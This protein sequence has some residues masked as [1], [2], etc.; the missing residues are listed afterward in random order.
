MLIGCCVTTAG[1]KDPNLATLVVEQFNC[2]TP[3]YELM[4][5]FMVDEGW[6]FTFERGDKV[7]AFAE[8]NHLPVFGHMLVWQFVTRKWLFEDQAGKPLAREKAL[9]NLKR[10]INEVM[11]HYHGRIKAWNVVN[12]AISD[13]DGE[14]LKDTPALRAIGDDYVEKVFE[15]AHTADPDVELY[16]NDYNIEQPDKLGKTVTL[17]RSLKANGVRID[18]VAYKVITSSTG[19]RR[20]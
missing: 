2:I 18:A 10:Y 13:K 8:E 14:Y 6:K 20:I 17:V 5:E 15:F 4:P 7:L 19:R 1:L 3:E 16:Y 9:S 12:E 11:H